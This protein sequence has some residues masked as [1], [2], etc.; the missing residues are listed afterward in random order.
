MS[1]FLIVPNDTTLFRQLE[2]YGVV[3]TVD[4]LGMARATA[5]AVRSANAHLHCLRVQVRR[6]LTALTFGNE[7]RG[8]PI[9][10]EVPSSG[11]GLAGFLHQLPVLK[12]LDLRVYLPANSR[13]NLSAVRILSSLGIETALDLRHHDGDWNAVADA[14]TYALLNAVEHASIA[15][16]NYLATRYSAEH[17]NDYGAVYFDDPNT[18][19]HVD[20]MLN[21]ALTAADLAAGRFAGRGREAIDG[22]EG[23]EA[24]RRWKHAWRDFFLRPD[25]CAYCAGWRV[26]LGKYEASMREHP[27]CERFAEEFMDAI[28]Q[29]RGRPGPAP[30]V[31]QP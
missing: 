26:C 11:Q 5:D 10:L 25:G 15:P 19:L 24:Y 9:A 6:P 8:I 14:M 1:R 12:T 31:W 17:R 4:S 22:I 27:G 18:Y 7:L 13:E 2:G 21:V 28:D 29:A 30:Q 3:A 20:H 23:L 16:F